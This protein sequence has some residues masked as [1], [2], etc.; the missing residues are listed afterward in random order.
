[1][2][3]NI[4]HSELVSESQIIKALY[5]LPAGWKWVRLGECASYINGRA[6]KPEE[7]E[8]EG[9]PIIR[10]QNLTNYL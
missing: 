5:E 10:I 6:F 1:M 3:E 7:W 4:C 2:K 9:K 8:T